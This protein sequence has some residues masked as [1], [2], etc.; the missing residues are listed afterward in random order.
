MNNITRLKP[1]P[2]Y[3]PQEDGTFQKVRIDRGRLQFKIGES[4]QVKRGMVY[5]VLKTGKQLC[6]EIKNDFDFR[7]RFLIQHVQTLSKDGIIQIVFHPLDV[8][9][10]MSVI[11]N[12]KTLKV[13][14]G[15]VNQEQEQQG[16][17]AKH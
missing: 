1:T 15:A 12:M 2:L 13:N 16:S 3:L 7:V 9:N 17:P 10:G 5:F 6:F 11:A 14:E 8:D 4:F